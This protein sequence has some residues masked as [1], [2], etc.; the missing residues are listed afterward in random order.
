MKIL[1]ILR[2]TEKNFKIVNKSLK[3]I[4]DFIYKFYDEESIIDYAKKEY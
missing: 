1:T 3:I 2:A 4:N